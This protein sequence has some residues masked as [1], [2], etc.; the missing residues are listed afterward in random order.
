MS[1]MVQTKPCLICA[2]TSTVELTEVEGAAVK[3]GT[4]MQDAL[5]NRDA[6][7][8]ELLITGTHPECWEQT[9][10]GMDDDEDDAI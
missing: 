1:V 8:R 5:P 6:G 10:G 7:F 4:Y 3:S 2:A 9:F